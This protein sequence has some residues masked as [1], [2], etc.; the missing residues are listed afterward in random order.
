MERPI[1]G[2]REPSVVIGPPLPSPLNEGP[3]RERTINLREHES[4]GLAV[5]PA[6]AHVRA[7]ILA[8]LDLCTDPE[9]LLELGPARRRHIRRGSRSSAQS[10]RVIVFA[11]GNAIA[12]R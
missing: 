4:L 6:R 9:A 12:E 2:I 3:R 1:D 7:D 8:D 10:D 11:C 5:T